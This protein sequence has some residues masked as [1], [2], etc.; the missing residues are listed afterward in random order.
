MS[1]IVNLS[2][3]ESRHQRARVVRIA[4]RLQD[5]YGLTEAEALRLAQCRDASNEWSRLIDKARKA[6]SVMIDTGEC[7]IEKARLFQ[8]AWLDTGDG[9][10]E[11]VA[12]LAVVPCDYGAVFFRVRTIGGEEL[13]V[14]PSELS[15]FVL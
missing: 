12:I 14:W 1:R 2:E 3:R 11:P 10:S 9:K 5:E 6:A 8:T 13:S 15:R 4:L 7:S